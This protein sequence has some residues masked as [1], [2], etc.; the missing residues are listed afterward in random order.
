MHGEP[1]VEVRAYWYS[2]FRR[3][4]IH[5]IPVGYYAQSVELVDTPIT[6]LQPLFGI[7]LWVIVRTTNG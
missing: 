4:G 5:D 7:E 6:E 3:P 1:A 2:G